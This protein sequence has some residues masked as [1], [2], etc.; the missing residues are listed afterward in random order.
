[1]IVILHCIA[2]FWFEYIHSFHSFILIHSSIQYNESS[3]RSWLDGRQRPAEVDCAGPHRAQ[4]RRRKPRNLPTE[5]MVSLMS[6][7]MKFIKFAV[8]QACKVYEGNILQKTCHSFIL[9]NYHKKLSYLESGSMIKNNNN[10]NQV[11]RSQALR[12]P[13][14]IRREA[15]GRAATFDDWEE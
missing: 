6:V 7:N 5:G 14:A 10:Q 9:F 13:H 3:L 2:Q 1:M 4:E 8:Y 11:L 15:E 12:R